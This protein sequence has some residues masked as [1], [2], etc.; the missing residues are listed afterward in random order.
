MLKTIKSKL[1]FLISI[2]LATI[3]FFGI[4]SLS[5]LNAV[6][7]KSTM[8]SDEMVPAIIFSEQL[9][10]M[11]SDFRILEYEHI[12]GQSSPI[13]SEKEKA[14]ELQKKEIQNTIDMYTKTIT[15]TADEELFN[16]AQKQWEKYLTL[17]E[18]MI[19]L[20]R[21]LKTEEAMNIMDN[22][23][24]E[25]FDL[26]SD[27]LLGLANLNKGMTRDVSLEGDKQYSSAIKF[28]IGI[29]I[30]LSAVGIC[31]SI[32]I[33]GSISKSL[34]ILKR[35]LDTLSEKGGDLTQ[36][37][38]V[39][40]KD[41]INDVANSL[42]KFIDNIRG[43]VSS[44]NE[45]TDSIESVMNTI[46]G[47]V[48][49][50]NENIEEVSA[51]TEELSATMEETAA[52]AEEMSATSQ[53][54]GIAV[55]SISQKSKEGSVK[56]GQI[57]KR[58]EDVKQKVQASRDKAN[59]IF[60]VT[61]TNLEKAIES[62]K[63]VDKITVLSQG[64]MDISSQT[65][66]LA[67][68]AAIEAAR[69]GE[70]GK[71]FSVVAEEIRKLAEQSKDTVTEIQNITNKVTK[72]VVDLSENSNKLLEFMKTDVTDDYRNM[73]VIAD[74]YTKDAEF[75]DNLV[76]N[77]SST[78]EELLTSLSEVLKTIDG[79]SGAASEGAGGTTDIAIRISDISNKSNGLSE[80]AL[81]SKENIVKLKQDISKFKI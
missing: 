72:S 50:L 81:K 43:I 52:S 80:E 66:L 1:T 2:L 74:N 73:L 77:F 39:N 61:K 71:G 46:N 25:A 63:I 34:N 65:N 20:S 23:S 26:A 19:E 40:S 3:I 55:E 68:N 16:T 56:A 51:T 7:S 48:K 28:T 17:N 18:E 69:A 6:N 14:M 78:S 15:T 10:T 4:Y 13:M 62:S 24:K 53:E 11:T 42:N 35:E 44:V 60:I 59:E 27:S 29:I 79:V 12:L 21:Q 36:K 9:N 5:I 41:E 58:A 57:N 31:I 30:V 38:K 33:I 64:I 67:L 70:A 47:T 49:D 76:L 22:E 75:V 37:I 8:I 45:S 32:F 54:I